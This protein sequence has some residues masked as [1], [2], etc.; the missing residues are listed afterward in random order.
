MNPSQTIFLLFYAV[1][2]GAIFTISDKW[3]PFT[4]AG[5]DNPEG[6][7]RVLSSVFFLVLL[8]VFYFILCVNSLSY[9][10]ERGSLKF[11]TPICLVS[12]LYAFYVL[13]AMLVSSKK[14]IFYS[15]REQ[16]SPVIH[17][18]LFWTYNDPR[19]RR[20]LCIICCGLIV[21]SILIVLYIMINSCLLRSA[22]SLL[23]YES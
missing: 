14:D 13:W 7:K 2:Y 17:E 18:S 8:P 3:K 22:F 23:S 15:H 4:Y 12:P 6:R 20:Y 19:H 5:S 10:C 1:L 11:L 16:I 9:I 21:L